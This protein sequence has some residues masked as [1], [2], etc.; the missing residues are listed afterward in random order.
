MGLTPGSCTSAAFPAEALFKLV[1]GT[2]AVRPAVGARAQ[3][4]IEEST[5]MRSCGRVGH[6]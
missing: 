5:R 4:W 2:R 3:F 6:W 1:I